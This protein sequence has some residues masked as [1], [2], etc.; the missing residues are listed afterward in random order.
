MGGCERPRS[1]AAGLCCVAAAAIFA[2]VVVQ[3]F[4][5]CRSFVDSFVVWCGFFSRAAKQSRICGGGE[6]DGKADGDTKPFIFYLSLLVGAKSIK[7]SPPLLTSDSVGLYRIFGGFRCVCD[8]L[9]SY[10][11]NKCGYNTIITQ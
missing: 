10:T 3:L 6:G 4:P 1:L 8:S 5:V 11:D 7:V 2:S 9:I